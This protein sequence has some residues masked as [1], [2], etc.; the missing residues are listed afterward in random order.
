MGPA[1]GQV[2]GQVCKA[3]GKDEIEASSRDFGGINS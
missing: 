2:S 1:R 3:E